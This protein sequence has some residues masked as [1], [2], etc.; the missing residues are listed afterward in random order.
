[1]SG[2]SGVLVRLVM[3]VSDAGQGVVALGQK[4]D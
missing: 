4:Y 3:Q 2:A 1:M